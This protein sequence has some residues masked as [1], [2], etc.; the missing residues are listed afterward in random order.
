MRAVTVL[1]PIALSVLA[2]QAQR[3]IS[4]CNPE[5]DIQQIYYAHRNSP[6][7]ANIMREAL[8]TQPDNLFLNYWLITTPGLR[9]GTFAAEYKAKLAAHR[10]E[11]LFQFLYAQALLGADTPEAIGLLDKALDKNPDIPYAYLAQLTI[12]ASATFRDRA[13]VARVLSRHIIRAV[14]AM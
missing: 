4:A 5:P 11:P 2:A 6:D 7:R 1:C 9:P 8:A 12:Y 14:P 10:D 3:D 13:R